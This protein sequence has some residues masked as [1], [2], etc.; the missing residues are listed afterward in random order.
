MKCRVVPVIELQFW[1]AF[2][3]CEFPVANDLDLWDT[4]DAGEV[5]EH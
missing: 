1:N 5:A 4:G 3:V 2:M